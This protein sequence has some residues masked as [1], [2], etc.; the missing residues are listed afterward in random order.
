MTSLSRQILD[1]HRADTM[2]GRAPDER[3]APRPD[4]LLIGPGSAAF[5][6]R[7]AAAVLRGAPAGVKALAWTDRSLTAPA[8]G[9]DEGRELI[10]VAAR[11]SVPL[12]APVAGACEPTY[13]EALAAPGRLVA[14]C[15]MGAH[16]SGALGV[17]TW[18]VTP[19]EAAALLCGAPVAP[20]QRP[21]ARLLFD[22]GLPPGC[23]GLDAALEFIRRSDLRHWSGAGIEI[24][25]AGVASLGFG[26][27]V[28]LTRTLAR[29]GA[30]FVLVPSDDVTRE[31]LR[32]WGRDAD[33]R[34]VRA[35][36]FDAVRQVELDLN[37]IEPLVAP[38]ADLALARPLRHALEH[39]LR[40]VSLGPFSDEDDVA[41]WL[42]RLGGHTVAAGLD[43]SVIAG[44]PAF[45]A[46]LVA[47]GA[48]DALEAAGVTM[49]EAALAEPARAMGGTRLGCGRVAGEPR[50]GEWW[51][52]NPDVCAA[53]AREGSLADPRHG[54]TAGT[55]SPRRSRVA[56][57]RPSAPLPLQAGRITATA[58]RFATQSSGPAG[59]LRAVVWVVVGDD[60]PAERIVSRS[61]RARHALL[62][63]P[64][65]GLF[66][67]HDRQWT[68]L[69]GH[70]SR[71][72]IA[73]GREFGGGEGA[74]EA[75]WALRRAGV[76]TVIARSFAPGF[77]RSL[78]HAGVLALQAGRRPL[79]EIAGAGEE[80]EIPSLPEAVEPGHPVSV[81]NLTRGVQDTL[82][83]G[84]DAD[85]VAIWRAGGLLA[86]AV[87]PA[88]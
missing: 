33:W 32:A 28:A 68:A 37:T 43:V 77:A 61:A 64:V 88:A 5:V 12:L 54:S 14:T 48:R 1:A 76:A 31:T 39:P 4:H 30:A 52:A 26:D 81:R 80:L 17:M 42:K 67:G 79:H 29:W 21:A 86:R 57:A 18:R 56:D 38:T 7:L 65:A 70:D 20:P 11:L 40:A 36:E 60:W 55:R 51:I 62:D 15:G 75:A 83:H 66:P 3:I 49:P 50:E 71:G 25:G 22:G 72:V 73:A 34:E 41:T 2:P 84:L 78:V 59:S 45:A 23:G 46:A 13:R 85:A 87:V 47:E 69:V 63:D 24:G 8:P 19:L 53:S 74:D 58:D 82:Y 10:D 9:D 27:R 44:T 16:A 35:A 6:L